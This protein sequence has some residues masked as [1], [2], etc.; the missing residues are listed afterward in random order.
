MRYI[1]F[2]R[3]LS[4]NTIEAYMRDLHEFAAYVKSEL[5]IQEPQ[6]VTHETIERYLSKIYDRG[7]SKRTQSR[8]L[9]SLRGFFKFMILT[10]IIT[11][12]PTEFI[13]HPIEPSSADSSYI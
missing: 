2:E 6:N 13:D 10:E 7:V 8:I 4:D 9:S 1:K 3:R 11:T 5:D 12:S